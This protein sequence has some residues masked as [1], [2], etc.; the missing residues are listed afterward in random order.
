MDESRTLRMVQILF[1][2][3]GAA[4]AIVFV[5]Y[6]FEFSFASL[7][8]VPKGKLVSAATAILA[9]AFG[10]AWIAPR[11][12]RLDWVL[13]VLLATSGLLTLFVFFGAVI[14]RGG[15]GGPLMLAVALGLF[16]ASATPWFTLR[17]VL[18]A[19]AGR[20]DGHGHIEFLDGGHGRTEL[21]AE[22]DVVAWLRRGESNVAGYREDGNKA[23]YEAVRGTREE[24]VAQS[25]RR[26]AFVVLAGLTVAACFIAV[27]SVT[28]FSFAHVYPGLQ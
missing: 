9:A 27:Q 15:I 6:A 21:R 8:A 25:R 7:G 16:A 2:V 22:G 5:Q 10:L 1:G 4:T 18:K 26:A 14:F 17:R 20:S 19:R 24:L 13:S 12:W 23:R 11:V 3:I 28:F